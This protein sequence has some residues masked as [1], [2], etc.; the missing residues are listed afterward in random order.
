M[1]AFL[2]VELENNKLVLRSRRGVKSA[3][4][5]RDSR[6]YKFPFIRK[7]EHAKACFRLFPDCVHLCWKIRG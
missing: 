3:P 4:L 2:V 6:G 5:Q 1:K 7:T